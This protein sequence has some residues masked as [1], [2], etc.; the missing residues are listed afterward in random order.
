MMYHHFPDLIAAYLATLKGR[1]QMNSR[2]VAAQW[3]RTLSQTPTRKEILARH[4]AKGQGH[5]QPGASQANTELALMRSAC[6]W[7][8][9]QECW[10][11]GDPTAGVKKWQTPRRKRVAKHQEIRVLLDYFEQATDEKALRDR[12][13]FGLMLFTGCR[14]GEARTAK[15]DSITVYG[16]MGCWKKGKTKNG[17]EYEVPLPAQLMPWIAAWKAVRQLDRPNPYLFP[18]QSFNQPIGLGWVVHRWHELR[19]ML[20]IQ[21][22]WN[23]D[24]RRSLATHMSNEL[25]Y[26]DAKIDAI[27]GHEKTSSLGHYLHVSFDAMTGPIQH[28][29]DWL[30]GLGVVSQP[31][32]KPVPALV[33]YQAGEQ[34]IR[35]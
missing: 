4:L 1:T 8:L 10:D 26:S 12:A 17:E 3:M 31:V 30:C 19:L 32:V 29:A 24:L 27:L 33:Q 11:G 23:Y 20:R 16:E 13:I 15:L 21:G 9:Y 25:N 22:L 28:Y 34:E 5:F 18:G 7:G 6:L 14:P 2:L 35:A